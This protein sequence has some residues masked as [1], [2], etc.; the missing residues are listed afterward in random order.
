M[1]DKKRFPHAAALAV[2]TEL[3]AMISP[4]CHRVA[5]A[6]SLRR[7]KPEVG[8]IE[9]LFI[10]RMSQRPD[11]LFDT[12]IVD[13]CAEV[14]EKLLDDGILAKRPNVN[15]H[16]TW[17]EKNKL[18]IHVASGIPVDFFGTAEANW[19]VSLV[20]RTG[21]KD[22]NLRLTTGANRKGATLMAYGSGVKWSD[23]TITAATSEEHVFE[24]CGVPYL[25]PEKR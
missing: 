5:I 9:L 2:A 11:G 6:G 18:A 7:G 23:G 3:Q 25:S 20:I 13:V 8:D 12:R 21:S 19:F 24:M 10:P 22:T 16:F 15:G 1:S 14:C 4:A 17:G